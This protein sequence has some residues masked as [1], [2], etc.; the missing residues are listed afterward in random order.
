MLS[1]AYGDASTMT[2][3]RSGSGPGEQRTFQARSGLVE[4]VMPPR[5]TVTM[6]KAAF[7]EVGSLGNGPV[8]FVDASASTSFEAGCIQLAARELTQMRK[9]GLQRIVAVTPSLTI[10]MG[11][12]AATLTSAIDMRVVERRLDAMPFLTLEK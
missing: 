1:C 12:R 8:W 4:T 11:A 7:A 3:A 6:L 10:R 2:E 9:K 5:I